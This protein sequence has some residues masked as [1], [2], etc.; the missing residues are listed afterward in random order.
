MLYWMDHIY[1]RTNQ[2]GGTNNAWQCKPLS[3]SHSSLSSSVYFL[4]L[5]SFGK[6]IKVKASEDNS[7]P[8]ST[9]TTNTQ[10]H[11]NKTHIV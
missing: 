2:L 1:S 9:R 10:S 6:L 7:N 3:I 4:S 8:F 5:S 11:A